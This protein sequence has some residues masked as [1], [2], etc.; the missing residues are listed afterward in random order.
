MCQIDMPQLSKRWEAKVSRTPWLVK[1][2]G[3]HIAI[4][5]S[6]GNPVVKKVV[7]QLSIEQYSQLSCNFDFIVNACNA[8]QSLKEAASN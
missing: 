4:M 6:D 1:R 8:A 5:D 7:S 2:T 3:S